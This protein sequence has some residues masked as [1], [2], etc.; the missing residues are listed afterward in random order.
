MLNYDCTNVILNKCQQDLPFVKSHCDLLRLRGGSDIFKDTNAQLLKTQQRDLSEIEEINSFDQV[1]IA[2]DNL[3]SIQNAER[4]SDSLVSISSSDSMN[5]AKQLERL[6]VVRESLYS[7]YGW[8]SSNVDQTSKWDVD[9]SANDVV[10]ADKFT[11]TELTNTGTK[12]WETF[13]PTARAKQ[14]DDKIFTDT[15]NDSAIDILNKQQPNTVLV[16]N[17]KILIRQLDIPSFGLCLTIWR[18]LHW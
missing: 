13:L 17:C 15:W 3:M 5:V 7:K 11:E 16:S 1:T 2:N 12:P 10:T 9:L 4:K 14:N 6:N 8:G 18:G